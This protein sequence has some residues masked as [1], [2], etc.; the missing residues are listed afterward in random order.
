MCYSGR[1]SSDP[2]LDRQFLL[3]CAY[4]ILII[5]TLCVIAILTLG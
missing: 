1:D 3:G 5:G 4:T 2:E